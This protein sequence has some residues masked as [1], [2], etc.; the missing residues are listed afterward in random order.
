MFTQ[1]M[2]CFLFFKSTHKYSK[3]I[4]DRVAMKEIS[5]TGKTQKQSWNIFDQAIWSP[6]KRGIGNIDTISQCAGWR[7]HSAHPSTLWDGF[8]P[9]FACNF[10]SLF[11]FLHP[12]HPTSLLIL[13]S[14]FIL[15]LSISFLPVFIVSF[16]PIL[17]LLPPLSSPFSPLFFH[18]NFSSLFPSHL[19]LFS[20]L[21]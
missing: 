21:V 5:C 17:H 9:L 11:L 10:V 4:F 18:L 19:S 1:R 20:Y 8:S 3:H 2:F 12:L 6:S 16:S 15:S 7:D 14:L 13:S